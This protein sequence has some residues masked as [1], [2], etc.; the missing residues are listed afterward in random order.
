M[1]LVEEMDDAEINLEN[2]QNTIIFNK[3]DSS[4]PDVVKLKTELDIYEKLY[5]TSIFLLQLKGNPAQINNIS[6]YVE[7]II[8]FQ[9]GIV[10]FDNYVK[11]ENIGLYW[12]LVDIIWIFLFPLFYLI[13]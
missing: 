8:P 5:H 6:K 7:M 3:N 11:L 10:T 13:T 2:Q 9:T 4:W 12:H 1:Q